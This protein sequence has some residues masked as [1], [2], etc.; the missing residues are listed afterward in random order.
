MKATS[1]HFELASRL[2]AGAVVL[3]IG[4]AG[5]AEPVPIVK[6]LPARPVSEASEATVRGASP[7]YARPGGLDFT[8]PSKVPAPVQPKPQSTVQPAAKRPNLLDGVKSMFVAKPAQAEQ[9]W[10]PT[11]E[12]REPQPKSNVPAAPAVPNPV[13]EP[14]AP[15]VYAGSPAYRWYGYGGVTPGANPY[16]PHG[17]YPKAS[18]NWYV[19]TGATP[20]AFPTMVGP[21]I[22]PASYEP[23]QYVAAPSAVDGLAKPATLVAY[24]RMELPANASRAEPVEKRQDP[25]L[26]STQIAPPAP[27]VPALPSG[28]GQAMPIG[29][30]L[31]ALPRDGM[32]W[33]PASDR[34]TPI[35]ESTKSVTPSQPPPVARVSNDQRVPLPTV[36][37]DAIWG[38]A[39][40][41]MPTI[42]PE[43][44]PKAAPAVTMIRGQAPAE[45]NATIS[46]IETFCAARRIAVAV[47]P[48]A[49]NALHVTFAASSEAEARSIAA[50]ISKLPD[51]AAIEVTFEARLKK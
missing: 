26:V 19:Q 37:A 41:P 43:E 15:A 28:A 23:P 35:A 10:W 36:P 39:P 40:G 2:A 9:P 4:F 30:P 51:L 32:L 45:S 5:A 33:Q 38:P 44:Q 42:K 7:D 22:K 11:P 49:G 25:V 34:G 14:K 1:T 13:V 3:S 47:K 50:A 48:M 27:T 6:L 24:E 31:E 16:A 17:L 18:T 29:S 20:G 8:T 12:E 46:A 21:A